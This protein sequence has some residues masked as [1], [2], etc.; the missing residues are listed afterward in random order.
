MQKNS[1]LISKVFRNFLTATLL[2]S[3]STQIALFS[4]GIIASNFIAPEALSA[5]NLTMP[6]TSLMESIILFLCMGASV[7]AAKKIGAQQYGEASRVFSVALI[8]G[9]LF[10]VVAAIFVTIFNRQIAFFMF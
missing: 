7:I 4:D 9:V 5:M 8:S 10:F 1:Y 2:T 3:I 6:I